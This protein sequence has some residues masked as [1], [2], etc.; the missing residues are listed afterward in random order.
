MTAKRASK[1]APISTRRM[2]TPLSGDFYSV[3]LRLLTSTGMPFVVGGAFAMKHYAGLTRGTK[4]LDVFLRE[5]DLDYALAKL[6]SA[7]IVT[8]RTFPHWLAKGYLGDDFVDLIHNSANGLCPV[9]DGWFAN[10]PR[11]TLFDVAARLCPIEEV[12]WTKSFVMERERFDGAD[13]CHLIAAQRKPI[14]WKHLLA[15]YGDNW[16]V[17]Y[18]HLVFFGFVYPRERDKVPKWVM[19]E[20]EERARAHRSAEDVSVC[21]GTLLSREQYLVDVNE[22]GYADAR[23]APW[24]SVAKSSLDIWTDAIGKN[25]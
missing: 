13:V 6:E 8:E 17:L 4:D 25:K 12:I 21:R 5:S 2:V 18:G 11:I 24:G 16:P 3:V 15:R 7:G 1:R 20:L 14:D 22:R 10:A 23:L 19:D 9:D